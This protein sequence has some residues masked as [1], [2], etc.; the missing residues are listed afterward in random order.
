M[1][2]LTHRKVQYLKVI[3]YIRVSQAK[4]AINRCLLQLLPAVPWL[5]IDRCGPP[6]ATHFG[7]DIVL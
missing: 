4:P 7:S 1:K 6:T 5:A 2:H 3:L